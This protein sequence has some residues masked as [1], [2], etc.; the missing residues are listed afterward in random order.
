MVDKPAPP[1]ESHSWVSGP[2]ANEFSSLVVPEREDLFLHSKMP[3]TLH[4]SIP[5]SDLL[6]T[7]FILFAVMYVYQISSREVLS[8]EGRKTEV[9]PGEVPGAATSSAG[10]E[11]GDSTGTPNRSMSNIYDLSKQTV[12]AKDLEHF[13]SVELVPD[14]A[15]RIILTGDLLF[16]TGKAD[17]KPK[18][19]WSL[20]TI[21]EIIRQVPYMVSVVGH[22]DNVP[23]HSDKF[24]TNWELSAIRACEVARFLIEE[25]RIPAERFYVSGHSYHQPINPNDT[26]KNRAANRRVEIIITKERPYGIPGNVENVAS[27]QAVAQTALQS[28]SEEPSGESFLRSG[29]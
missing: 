6:M 26:A 13:A 24:P 2:T 20:E 22:T 19:R 11:M 10:R 4:W 18:A 27:L 12:K 5:W 17:L 25:M 3:K 9:A 15:V 16:D 21:A 29:H 28:R 23:I 1:K 8:S 7:M 14:K